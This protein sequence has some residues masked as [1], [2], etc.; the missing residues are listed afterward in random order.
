MVRS[1][2]AVGRLT[3]ALV[4]VASGCYAS[5]ARPEDAGAPVDVRAADAPPSLC[6]SCRVV[7]A[8]AP[9]LHARFDGDLE[10]TGSAAIT[11]V[12]TAAP[13]FVPGVFGRALHLSPT[14]V[15][16]YPGTAMALARADALTFSMWVRLSRSGEGR[17]FL[18]CRSFDRGFELYAGVSRGFVTC[19]G[20]GYGPPR[21]WGACQSVAEGVGW[22]H[23]ILR[24]AGPGTEPE[25][26]TD[27]RPW[28]G[29]HAHD[30]FPVGTL[31]LFEGALDLAVGRPAGD[32][33]F[34]TGDLEVDD[35]RVYDVA[36]PDEVVWEATSCPL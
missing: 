6:P 3:I 8:P 13:A 14:S 34:A 12:G 7:W 24:W 4:W 30:D 19:A 27:C 33:S 17:A 11:G 35:L 21:A 36:L 29:L 1:P 20:D 18:H 28:V 16:V 10:A 26:A 31:D 25:V 23:Y 9:I 5:H 32:G 2:V 22:T 15:V